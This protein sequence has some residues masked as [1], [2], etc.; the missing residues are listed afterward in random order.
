M[1][2]DVFAMVSREEPIGLVCL[3]S[4]SLIKPVVCFDNAA[5]GQTEF[6]EEDCGFTGSFFNTKIFADKILELYKNPE[7]KEKLGKNVGTENNE[8]Y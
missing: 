2:I 7:L 4:A 6:V 8:N 5:G 3:E 1:A